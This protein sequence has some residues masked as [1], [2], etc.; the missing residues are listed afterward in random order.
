MV[1]RA[2]ELD[3][4]NGASQ[5][6]LG[7]IA[8]T[9]RNYDQAI[10]IWENLHEGTWFGGL[11][12]AYAARKR[13]AEAYRTLDKCGSGDYCL[14][15]RAWV[16]GQAGR[17]QDV[18]LVLDQFKQAARQRY[19]YPAVFLVLYTALGDKEQALNWLERAYEERDPWL[20]WLKVSEVV[21]PLRAEPRSQAV[22]RKVYP[23]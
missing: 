12:S 17:K 14:M 4:L 15:N 18:A 22:L 21:D 9:S 7:Q 19:V 1:R 23:E 10:T 2:I 3:P 8:L 11:A 16:S 13:F 6:Q 5:N 20:F